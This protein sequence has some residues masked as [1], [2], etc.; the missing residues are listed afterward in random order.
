MAMKVG[1]T[2]SGDLINED[3]ARFAARIGAT[4]VVV[5]LTDYARGPTWR[6]ISR[7]AVPSAA[8]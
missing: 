1:L 4:Y 7:E 5:H 3:G 6:P 8:E 2:L